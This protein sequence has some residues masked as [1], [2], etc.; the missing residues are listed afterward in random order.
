MNKVYKTLFIVWR[1]VSNSVAVCQDG[2]HDCRDVHVCLIGS[3]EH[4]RK[5]I[6]GD[7]FFLGTHWAIIVLLLV[8]F[9]H[10][11]VKER[12]ALNNQFLEAFLVDFV[13]LVAHCEFQVIIIKFS[14]HQVLNQ[15]HCDFAKIRV[16]LNIVDDLFDVQCFIHFAVKIFFELSLDRLENIC[17]S[18]EFQLLVFS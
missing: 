14:V 11:L 7:S 12:V 3:L 1:Q 2:D 16:F 15:S 8:I 13:F 6:V 4:C 9:Y 5:D 18:A 17:K 10:F